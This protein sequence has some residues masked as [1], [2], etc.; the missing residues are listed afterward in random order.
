MEK[1]KKIVILCGGKFAFRSLQLLAIEKFLYG[2]AIGKG[3][4]TI[5]DSLE[6]ETSNSGLPFKSFPTKKSV[7]AMREWLDEIQ[8]DYIFS[9]S[10]P[11]L[12]PESVLSYGYD[13]F[14]NFHPAPLPRYRGAMPIFEVLRN[15]ENKTAICAHFMNDKFD[16]GNIIFNDPITI[17]KS[18]TYGSLTI[19]LSNRMSQIVLNVANMLEYGTKIPSFP[20]NEDDACYYEKPELLDTYINWKSMNAIEIIA[21]INACNPWNVGADATLLGEQIKI[22]SAIAIDE[23]HYDSTVGTII[24]ITDDGM[25]KVA[26]SD[27]EVIAVKILA[28]DEGIMT[29][30]QYVQLKKIDE[31]SL[32]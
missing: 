4:K 1:K 6:K 10:F 15:Q 19:K 2:I 3:S 24:A 29:S 23:R 12:I 13:K 5:I 30:Q 32:I 11:F 17:E 28:T 16:Q 22:I 14:I 7:L 21:L 20:Q 31:C 8:P 25:I 18:E 9:I 27:N 26:C